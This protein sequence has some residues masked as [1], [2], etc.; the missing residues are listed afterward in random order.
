MKKLLHYILLNACMI[1]IIQKHCIKSIR[2]KWNLK[3]YHRHDTKQL[4]F[5][6]YE[7]D[8]WFERKI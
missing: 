3:T 1:T 4:A 5:I 2:G 7:G 8:L 6:R